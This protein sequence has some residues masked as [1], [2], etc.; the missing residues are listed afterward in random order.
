MQFSQAFSYLMPKLEKDL[1]ATLLFHNAQHTKDVIHVCQQLAEVEKLAVPERLI[2]CTAALFHDAGFLQDYEA[3]EELSCNMARESLPQ[4]GY[5]S[6]DIEQ[7]CRL[8]MATRQG[9]HPTDKLEALLCDADMSY[10]GT[11]DYFNRSEALYLEMQQIGKLK[12]WEEWQQPE[13]KFMEAHRYHSTAA[14]KLFTAH[15]SQNF[16]LFKSGVRQ[17]GKQADNRVQ[18]LKD[19][20]LVILGVLAAAFGLKG[21]LVPAHFFDGG[22]T[23]IALI[24]HTAFD[25]NLSLTTFVLNMPFVVAGYVIV[26]RSFAIKA[27]IGVSLLCLFLLIV[28][29]QSITQDKLLIAFFGGFFIG[30]GSGLAIRS[31]AVL[32]GT[33]VLALYTRRLTNFT[34]SEIILAINI[35]IFSMAALVENLESALYSILTYIVASKTINYVVEGF[36]AY[37]GVTI[38]S[39]Q[40]EMLKSRLVNE[41]RRS[42]TVYKGERGY[43]P[44]NMINH[45]D[46]DIIMTVVSRLEMGKL[47]KLVYET[48]PNAF[49]FASTISEASGGIHKN[50]R[51]H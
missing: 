37:T 43:L 18:T 4:F 14:I 25:V 50:K 39:A 49:M 38:V 21:F 9:N 41:L 45:S 48:D 42:I 46:C 33:E 6:E 12:T 51:M 20:A 2:L 31:G 47:K 11:K 7:V 30:I 16:L 34:I 1:P 15:K 28:P 36:E 3:H 8:I 40:S 10:L 5:S 32:D 22:V 24:L 19:I 29:A 44:G 26:S 27:F 17:T 35:V 23:G 13:L